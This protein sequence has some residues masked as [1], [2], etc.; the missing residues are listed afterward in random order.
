MPE[1]SGKNRRTTISVFN[2]WKS[3]HAH[4]LKDCEREA[5]RSGFSVDRGLCK[6]MFLRLFTI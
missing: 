6:N 4:I 2:M 3:M 1:R 5:S